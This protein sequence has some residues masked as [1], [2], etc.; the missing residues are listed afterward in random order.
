MGRIVRFALLLLEFLGVCFSLMLAHAGRF[1]D[2]FIVLGFD[3]VLLIS[4]VT[5]HVIVVTVD[6]FLERRDESKRVNWWR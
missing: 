3:L 2:A 4:L 5:S 6:R 1:K